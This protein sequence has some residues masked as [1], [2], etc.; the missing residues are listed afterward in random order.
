MK[1]RSLGRTGVALSEIG[2]GAWGLG[3]EAYGPTD[4]FV[5]ER[6]LFAALDAGINF[7]D[8]SD[9]YGSGRSEELIG[10][11]A[12]GRRS[13]LL[14][15]TKGGTLPHR[16]FQMPQDF[17]ARHLRG[18]LESSL[19]R[20]GMQEV[21]L[22][23]L[24]SPTLEALKESDAFEALVQF[25][26]EGMIR[27]A[28]VSARSPLDALWVV[29]NAPVEV[30]Q[31]NFN[32]I[33][34]RAVEC[35]LLQAAQSAGIG[36][37]ARTPLCFGYLTG[38]LTGNE[39]LSPGDHRAHWPAAQLQRW[40]EAPGLFD[41]LIRRSGL[42]P[43]Q[44][45]LR[46]C[47]SHSAL[48]TVIPGMLTQPQV[49]ENALAST[50]PAL[51]PEILAEIRDIYRSHS[52]YDPEIKRAALA[53]S[54]SSPPPTPGRRMIATVPADP[55]VLS[56]LLGCPFEELPPRLKSEAI[57]LSTECAPL[58]PEARDA[59]L[60][61]VLQRVHETRMHRND[62]ENRQAFERGWSENLRASLEGGI[63]VSALTPRY[64]RPHGTI[65]WRGGLVSP[66][67]PFLA[68]KLLQLSVQWT[69]HRYLEGISTAYEFGCGSCQ[70]L[71]VLSTLRPDLQLYG[72]DFTQASVAI[73]ERLAAYGARVRGQAF[74]M[75]KPKKGF[76]L[77]PGSAVFTVGALEQ[78]GS[79][80]E[81]FLEYL[82]EQ[83]PRVVIHHEPILEFYNPDTLVDYAAILWHR[84][85]DYLHGYWPALRHAARQKRVEILK[86]RRPGFGDPYHESSSVIVWRPH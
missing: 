14:I 34:Q 56:N 19:R 18:A 78:L 51:P 74:D 8:T 58:D 72:L 83:K 84:K 6:T 40:A 28:G 57:S 61:H 20:L 15:A 80:F 64:V 73:V 16:G 48:S 75:L 81:P 77:Q 42:T 63:S 62:E 53:A 21:D 29:E 23:Q 52:F 59:H 10:R 7:F 67:D 41:K 45:A 70:F 31:V 79:R 35:G 65:R 69:F 39:T 54:H 2:F 85:R 17:S 26:N 66:R 11:V 27:F 38:T 25:R 50:S 68:H 60:L 82:I 9:L 12:A 47:L 49:E 30:I 22:Y 43:A 86:A 24:H 5:S 55:A 1:Y 4:D 32:L 76:L 3:G 13:Q 44:F 36:I 71:H 37:I 33:D 46:F